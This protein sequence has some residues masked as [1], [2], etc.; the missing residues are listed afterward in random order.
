MAVS[1][2][3]MQ[4]WALRQIADASPPSSAVNAIDAL[5]S[6]DSFFR[7]KRTLLFGMKTTPDA[8]EDPEALVERAN[9]G[10]RAWFD[11][12]GEIGD[13][14]EQASL[15]YAISYLDPT[16]PKPELVR[17]Q[18]AASAAHDAAKQ[19]ALAAIP[20]PLEAVAKVSTSLAAA[21]G[22]VRGKRPES[23]FEKVGDLLDVTGERSLSSFEWDEPDPDWDELVEA[24]FDPPF[25][26][27]AGQDGDYVGVLVLPSVAPV[28]H[29]SHEEG[30]AFIAE[31]LEHWNVMCELATKGGR[32]P[33]PALRRAQ[34]QMPK[35]VDGDAASNAYA[36]A[37]EAA[38]AALRNLT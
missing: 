11:H 24:A 13:A 7:S 37:F 16:I 1:K 36:A 28:M 27:F 15:Y 18:H 4:T 6:V 12:F 35:H 29:F 34:G 30:Y 19:K 10:L 22:T 14:E 32:G 38:R 8:F 17:Q 23:F 25:F 26:P 31:S 5:R 3:Q 9:A 2:Q 33:K 20:R 21:L